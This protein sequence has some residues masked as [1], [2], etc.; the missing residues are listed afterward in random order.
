MTDIKITRPYAQALYQL[1]ADDIHAA[2]R[3][4]QSLDKMAEDWRAYPDLRHFLLNPTLTLAI[5]E[6]FIGKIWPE[7]HQTALNFVRLLLSKGHIS[8]LPDVRKMFYHLREQAENIIDAHVSS[9][10]ELSATQKETM[11][12]RLQHTTGKTVRIEWTVLPELLAGTVVR[13]GDHVLDASLAH[14]LA[15]LHKVLRKGDRG[16]KRVAN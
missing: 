15:E 2:D 6:D 9:A 7:M 13:V 11:Q 8:A 4:E 5:K 1:V 10:V 16:G 12:Q 3:V 14:R